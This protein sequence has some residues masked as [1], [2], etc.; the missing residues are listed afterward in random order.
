M[1]RRSLAWLLLVLASSP[2]TAPFTTCDLATLFGHVAGVALTTPDTPVVQGAPHN[3]SPID[4]D[5][6]LAVSLFDST[7][8]RVKPLAIGP[9]SL[10]PPSTTDRPY[11]A[12]LWLLNP[13]R[14]LDGQPVAPTAL[15]L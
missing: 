1:T 14:L 6:A 8:D 7:P 10:Q 15:R 2:F 12:S 4:N 13:M 5:A 3:L 11:G 9:Y